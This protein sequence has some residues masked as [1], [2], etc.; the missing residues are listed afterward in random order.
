M[1]KSVIFG[2][3]LCMTSF[4]NVKAQGWLGKDLSNI[5]VKELTS[6]QRDEVLRAAKRQG[7]NEADLE[8]MA[9]SRGLNMNDLRQAQTQESGNSVPKDDS[10]ELKK[11]VV[12]S[13]ILQTTVSIYGQEL[14]DNNALGFAPSLNL[15]PTAGYVLGPNDRLSIRIF[16]LQE[17]TMNTVVGNNG[18]VV[19]P[20]GGKIMLSGLT[21]S[22]AERS[23]VTQLKK[24]G[25][26]SLG[27]GESQLKIQITEFRSIQVMVWGA[28]QSGAYYLPS[29]GTAFH[30]LFAAGGPGLNRS[31]RNIHVIRNGK[32]I[33]VIDLYDF[34]TKGSRSADITLQ[35]NDIVFIPYY[36]R[37]VRIRGEVKTP[38]VFEL[39][40]KE[41]LQEALG[42]AGGFT[43]IAYRDVVEVLRYGQTE[44]EVFSVRGTELNAF[45]LTG[46]EIVTV[47][48]ITDRFKNR[49]KVDG[50][51]ERPG[52]YSMAE[53]IELKQAIENAGGLKPNAVRSYVLLYR[54]PRTGQRSYFG[55][56]LGPVM[57]GQLKIVL[58]ENDMIMVGDSLEMN[59]KDQV[60]V[61]GDVNHQGGFDF[62]TGLSVAKVLFLAGGFEQ[63]ALTSNVIVSRK[64][65]D[66]SLLA[67]VSVLSARR[68][69][70]NDAEL[71]NFML[72]PGDVITVSRNPYYRDQVYVSCEGEFKIPGVYPLSS[73]KQ[74]LYDIYSLAGGSTLYGSMDGS[75][76]IRKRPVPLAARV[77]DRLKAKVTNELYEE[78]T[79]SSR[80]NNF[81]D[82]DG[83]QYDTIVIG[84]GKRKF[85]TTARSFYLQPGDRFIIPTIESTVRI[86]GE[87]Y[88]PNVIMYDK[89]LT[90]KKYI[91]MAGGATESARLR[92]VFVVY[93]NGRSA[94]TRHP[95]LLFKIQPKVKPGC[96]IIVPSKIKEDNRPY[97]MTSTERVTLY[98]VMA[99]TLSSMAF[100]IGQILK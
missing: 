84:G 30:A 22:E 50:A 54:N 92:D 67:T 21:I 76:I 6:S 26:A 90:M 58:E 5:N 16:G 36:E 66:E 64:V 40:P 46:S 69:F 55:Y 3:L 62:G 12:A 7:F 85:E 19:I 34:L 15:A 25:F 8:S 14:F 53:G 60:F 89:Q 86:L 80:E 93:Q 65:E 43:E 31:Y 24:Y 78:D 38:A 37:R 61:V 49:I 63:E 73:R 57:S 81:V 32:T 27:T 9:R 88:N 17:Q 20:Y 68:D 18:S 99:S 82:G 48:S 100:V 42:F 10:A 41:Q 11:K 97:P 70:W 74:T 29:L 45:T 33:R 1:N 2:W 28:K 72:E 52:Y 83:V 94:K 79:N 98:S 87:V 13:N 44:K 56:P 71:N 51:I 35:E 23:L 96:Q 59:R 75:L 77:T 39:L 91:E 4:F 95:L 47:S